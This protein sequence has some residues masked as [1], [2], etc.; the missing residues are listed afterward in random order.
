MTAAVIVQ[1]RMTSTRLPGK[2]LLDLAGKT[3]LAHCLE[4]CKAIPG[5]DVVVCAVPEGALH[6][7]VAAEAE[8]CGV[9]VTRGSEDDVL[10]R[11]WRAALA[12]KADHVL[13]VTSDCPMIDPEVCGRVLRLAT[14]GGADYAC[15]NMPHSWPHGMDCEAFPFAWLDRAARQAT[16]ASDR[17]HVSPFI[18]NHPQAVKASLPNPAGDQHGHRWTIDHPADY[19]FFKAV[20]ARLPAGPAGF[21]HRVALRLIEAEPE[22]AAINGGIDPLE[23]YKKSLA[24]DL[25]AKVHA[26][27]ATLK[28]GPFGTAMLAGD[29]IELVPLTLDCAKD[30]EHLARLIRWRKVGEVGFAR[31]VAVDEASTARWL[32]RL[33]KEQPDRVL[34]YLRRPGGEVFGHIGLCA[35]DA[36]AGSMMIEAV[37]RGEPGTGGMG[38]AI[39][40]LAR[41][42]RGL[43]LKRLG[44]QVFSDNL[45]ALALFHR[46]GLVPHGLVPLKQIRVEGGIEWAECAPGDR[47][48]RWFLVMSMALE[49]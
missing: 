21:S 11:Y 1:A 14:H 10:D 17:E 29:G 27:I 13:R 18:R 30:P 47:P 8:R 15:N 38:R 23:G 33:L 36:A 37:V 45:P 46:A 43:G 25:A 32:S 35:L 26:A 48:E 28:A 40:A 12:V 22:L 5:A 6:D 24:A 44:L 2:V 49:V 3:V 19:E 34:F 9:V 31:Q 4:R 16:T 39:A 20:F 42:A 7:P 41:W